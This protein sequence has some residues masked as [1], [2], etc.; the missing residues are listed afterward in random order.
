MWK[1]VVAGMIALLSLAPWVAAGEL[2]RAGEPPQIIAF[3]GNDLTGDHTHIV[4]DMRRLGKWDNSISSLVILSWTWEFFDDDD[5]T[6]TNMA[7][8]GPGQYP[9]V[10]EKGLKDNSISSIRLVSPTARAAKGRRPR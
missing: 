7:M 8:L 1:M 2:G 4:G 10:T 5:F 3:D 9:R 6:G